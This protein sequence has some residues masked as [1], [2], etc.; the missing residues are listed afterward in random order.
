MTIKDTHEERSRG[1]TSLPKWAKALVELGKAIS[2]LSRP[3]S[4]L[5]TL[6]VCLPRVDFAAG[7]MTLGLILHRLVADEDISGIIR[8]NSL[9]GEW[10][11]F[12]GD[13]KTLIGYLES[14]DHDSKQARIAVYKR[15]PPDFEEMSYEKRKNYVPPCSGALYYLIKASR[16]H[17]V[18]PTGKNYSLE[19]G[20]TNLGGSLHHQGH[21]RIIKAINHHFGNAASDSLLRFSGET[22][23]VLGNVSRLNK[24]LEE[25]VFSE[26]ALSLND[27]VRPNS[28]NDG[29]A[30]H[31]V[32]K[33]TAS[34][35]IAPEPGS[36]A[37][38]EATR[39]L[40]DH[41]S[42]TKACH[43]IIILGRNTHHYEEAAGIIRDIHSFRVS[44]ASPLPTECC[45][46]SGNLLIFNHQ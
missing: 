38:I 4:H 23:T 43:R 8:L 20:G 28:L 5:T 3:P 17:T 12:P 44:D 10:V 22:V 7:L 26:P 33:T 18:R 24:E 29:T 31:C 9:V 14:V 25:P 34:Q 1:I 30:I 32:I 21:D 37:I 15:Q 27:I 36:V 13:N 2:D 39:S 45:P 6:V 40:A 41:L 46:T 16:W 42:A 11:S 35:N 19:K